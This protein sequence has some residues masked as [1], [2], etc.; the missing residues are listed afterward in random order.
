MKD[1]IYFALIDYVYTTQVSIFNDTNIKLNNLFEIEEI[2]RIMFKQLKKLYIID[3][4][5]ID[6]INTIYRESTQFNDYIKQNCVESQLDRFLMRLEII[7][8]KSF[9]QYETEVF[10]DLLTYSYHNSNIDFDNN[11]DEY[12]DNIIKFLVKGYDKTPEK[13][14]PTVFKYTEIND[15]FTVLLARYGSLSKISSDD[16]VYISNIIKDEFEYLKDVRNTLKIQKVSL[17]NIILTG[18][19]KSLQNFDHLLDLLSLD[20]AQISYHNLTNLQKTVLLIAYNVLLGKQMIV[21]DYQLK[22]IYFNDTNTLLKEIVPILSKTSKIVLL[23]EVINMI[24]SIYKNTFYIDNNGIMSE[25]HNEQIPTDFD[26]DIVIDYYDE[27]DNIKT[28][29]F[30]R[31]NPVIMKY[32]EQYK[33]ININTY[34][35]LSIDDLI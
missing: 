23:E 28:E 7:L 20:Y 1:D 27:S 10:L 15:D 19:K 6:L 24:P 26:K 5:Y 17:E 21:I 3:S 4:R 14:N 22:F 30:E 33:I 29:Y 9:S 34:T 12:I 31:N 25:L 18:I 11:F 13:K 35:R 16:V 8:R 2:I 32:L